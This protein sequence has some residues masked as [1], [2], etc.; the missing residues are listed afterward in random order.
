MRYLNHKCAKHSQ[1]YTQ[2]NLFFSLRSL[3]P[4]FLSRAKM[5]ML[6]AESKHIPNVPKIWFTIIYL[7]APNIV[8]VYIYSL[9]RS[10]DFPGKPMCLRLS[11]SLSHRRKT[12]DNNTFCYNSQSPDPKLHTHTS[13]KWESERDSLKQSASVETSV[14]TKSVRTQVE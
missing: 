12:D 10:T 11:F 1:C 9:Y 6:Q 3:C 13:D 4:D 8:I 5:K 7:Y 2:I 14:G